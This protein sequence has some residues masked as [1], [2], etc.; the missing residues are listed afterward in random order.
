MN[1]TERFGSFSVR[2]RAGQ[3]AKTRR[4]VNEV[5]GDDAVPIR[6]PRT[7]RIEPDGGLAQKIREA[8][9]LYGMKDKEPSGK[10]SYR[11]RE[12]LALSAALSK[13][14]RECTR[15]Y[16]AAGAASFTEAKPKMSSADGIRNGPKKA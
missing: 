6:L 16:A 9:I 1:K 12:S 14:K 2:D 3:Y 10:N 4:P 13:Q 5:Y 11:V 8:E 15:A 7:R